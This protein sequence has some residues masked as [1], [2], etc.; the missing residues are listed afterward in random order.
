[1]H[2]DR[3]C[4]GSAPGS[5]RGS[6]RGG[7][8]DAAPRLPRALVRVPCSPGRPGDLPARR[9]RSCGWPLDCQALPAGR[10]VVALREIVGW[11]LS[12]TT[13]RTSRH[14]R[15]L[16]LVCGAPRALSGLD[17][18][19]DMTSPNGRTRCRQVSRCSEPQSIWR[20]S[21]RTADQPA[22]LGESVD[23]VLVRRVRWS[24]HGGAAPLCGDARAPTGHAPFIDAHLAPS[25]EV[26]GVALLRARVC[27]RR[28]S[29]AR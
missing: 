5:P 24:A 14:T 13:F 23:V 4:C 16:V 15:V 25:L 6:P 9:G 7:R 27:P 22:R 18:L 1:M 10:R 28:T 20:C 19:L 11:H 2:R 12:P 17:N 21:T 26:T 3:A 29:N 8:R